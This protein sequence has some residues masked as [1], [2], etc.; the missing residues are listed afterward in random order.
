MSINFTRA[1]IADGVSLSVIGDN[2]FK[3]NRLSVNFIVPLDES[4]VSGYALLPFVMRKGCRGYEDLMSL[5]RRLDEL[6]GS[7]LIADV[8]KSG[9]NQIITL[10]IKAMADR[11][12]LDGEQLLSQCAE[13]LSEI[14]FEPVFENGAFR[15]KDFELEQRF[16][17][18]TIEAQINDKRSY[19]VRKC[20]ELMGRGDASAISK[21][22]TIE[23]AKALTAES[24][25][26]SYKKLLSA[27]RIE[28]IIS[29][30]GDPSDAAAVIKKAFVG[31]SRTPQPLLFAK[32]FPAGDKPLEKVENM[33]VAQSK[34]VLGFR[35]PERGDLAFSAKVRMMSALYGGTPSSKLFLNVREKLSLC[36]YCAA[37]YDRST[38]T[39][40][41]DC[42]VES[43]NIESAKKEILLQLEEIKN[44]NFDDETLENTRL[45]IINSLRLVSDYTSG[46]EDW[47]LP[48]ILEG[49]VISPRE[50]M[51]AIETVTRQDVVDAARLV[52]LDAVYLLTGKEEKEDA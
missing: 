29:G 12:T 18:D 27:A 28:I 40:L 49:N 19:A 32:V 13:L 1:A 9:A 44:G 5:N 20:R 8:S 37:R 3:H 11:Y 26:E 7:V 22:G 48:R 46:L 16:L 52:A 10:G 42:G 4:T 36:Y 17:I 33:E 47:Y 21:Y 45:Q 14:I 38:A 15:Q 51:A 34:M 6:Y 24:V 30:S 39:M 43:Q 25:T 23:G 31:H 41:V 35:L 50:D 2:K